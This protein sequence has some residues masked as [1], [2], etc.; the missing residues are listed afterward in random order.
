M[1][2]MRMYEDDSDGY[3]VGEIVTVVALTNG[4]SM[5]GVIRS[6]CEMRAPELVLRANG[7]RDRE[8]P[9]PVYGQL[10]EC[11]SPGSWLGKTAFARL[12][13]IRPIGG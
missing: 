7:T 1:L 12:S 11:L 5:I 3:P 8:N 9:T 13:Q 2:P 6:G 10:V 4:E